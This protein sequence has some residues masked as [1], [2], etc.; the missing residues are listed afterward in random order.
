MATSRRSRLRTS[1]TSTSSLEERRASL[2]R[3]KGAELEWLTKEGVSRCD[4]GKLWLR[5]TR[6]GSSGKTSPTSYRLTEDGD[7]PESFNGW[8]NAGISVHGEYL[9]LN[10]SE[11]PNAA[12]VCSLSEVID[13]G[14]TLGRHYL[15]I[16]QMKNM[17][18]RLEKYKQENH[19]THA[20]R[21]CASGG[22]ETKLPSTE[23]K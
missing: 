10:T 12:V 11:S 6:A 9:T 5:L 4:S 18:R 21:M 3:F 22:Q 16:D 14:D 7:L 1:S 19:L 13:H 20:L 8:G 23:S 17:L 2:F 15:S